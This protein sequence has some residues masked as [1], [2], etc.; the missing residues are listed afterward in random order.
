MHTKLGRLLSKLYA[1]FGPGEGRLKLF[2]EKAK[3]LEAAFEHVRNGTIGM[4]ISSTTA[5]INLEV[6]KQN[7]LMLAGLMSKHYGMITQMLQAM[8]NPMLPPNVK[9]YMD[10]AIKSA[11]RLQNIILKHFNFDE[12]ELFVPPVET[13]N[14]QQGNPGAPNPAAAMA[15]LAGGGG[16][17]QVGGA[18]NTGNIQGPPMQQ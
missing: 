17:P 4:P 1:Q 11:N 6:E 16:L 13:Q 14:A 9:D 18:P 12:T 8:A 15:G 10:K 5:S 2:G 7:D 3:V